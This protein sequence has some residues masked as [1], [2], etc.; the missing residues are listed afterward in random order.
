MA[1]QGRLRRRRISRHS[2]RGAWLWWKVVG[3]VG[4]VAVVAWVAYLQVN[5]RRS[6][7][8][9]SS[10]EVASFEYQAGQDTQ[11]A[12]LLRADRAKLVR[13]AEGA[14]T[15]RLDGHSEAQTVN[16]LVVASGMSVSLARSVA[17]DAEGTFCAE[18]L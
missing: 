3:V 11:L 1:R 13:T 2:G 8:T 12:P 9:Y 7:R 18:V 16:H 15:Y 17:I 14:C 6:E 4:L 10:G 5:S